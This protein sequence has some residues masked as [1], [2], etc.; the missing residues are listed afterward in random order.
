MSG[1]EMTARRSWVAVVAG[2]VL[3]CGG[4]ATGPVQAPAALS[5]AGTTPTRLAPGDHIVFDPAASGGC[6]VVPAAGSAGAEYLVVAVSTTGQVT[7]AGVSTPYALAAQAGAG[8]TAA[9]GYLPV[10]SLVAASTSP[11]ARF[12]DMLRA[13]GR[14]L[15]LGAGAAL[16]RAVARLPAVAAAV[17]PV[18]SQR[19]FQV[20]GDPNCAGFVTVTATLEHAGTHGLVYL[21]T[22]APTGGFTQT[23]LDGLGALFD[24]FVYPI[25]TLSFGHETD[26]DGNG[27]VAILLSPAV[28]RLSGNC[29]R[30]HSVILGFFFPDD[31]LPGSPGSN[32]GEIFYG[33]VPDPNSTQ[34]AISRSFVLGSI[35]PTFLHELQH[36]IS[37]G[38]HVVLGGGAAEDN[39]LDE[40][41]SR[42]AEELGGREIPDSVCAPAT[43]LSQYPSGDLSNAFQYLN[44]DVLELSPLIEP[45]DVDGTLAD[46]GANWLFIRWLADHFAT[47]SILGRSL[48]R[49]LDGADS[50][51]GTTLVGDRN[52]AT[53]TGV[54]FPT[55]VS[56]WQL[57]NYLTSVTGFAEPTTRLPFKSWNLPAALAPQGTYPLQP[58]SVT[59]VGYTHSG[60]LRAGSG[61]HLRVIQAAN[62]PAVAIAFDGTVG[63]AVSP[64]VVPRFALARV[65]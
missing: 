59:T 45:G 62:G 37:Y 38:H 52:A 57:A 46:N 50:P 44:K 40:G 55:L 13:R 25:D 30:T 2:V 39:W 24:R 53:T 12:H 19:N 41:L 63:A 18:G 15:A 9:A 3:A 32:D 6:L 14:S 61:R 36:M 5:C 27:A 65:R 64:T 7:Q 20:C 42:L 8:L 22:A 10:A 43:C 1:Y 16:E 35:G 51:S 29:N 54:D 34:C 23:D 60:T 4:D 17:P 28:N 11:A 21:D 56:E 31:L 58:D 26:L 48:T 49:A 47:D 33:L